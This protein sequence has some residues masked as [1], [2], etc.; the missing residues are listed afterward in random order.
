MTDTVKKYPNILLDEKQYVPSAIKASV[1]DRPTNP[2]EVRPSTPLIFQVATA[3]DSIPQWG[4]RPQHRDI[5]LRSFYKS[6]P[7]L[8]SAIYQMSTKIASVKWEVIGKDPKAAQPKNTINKTTRMLTLSGQGIG[9][10]RFFMKV[11]VDLYTQ[12]NGAFIELIREK[13]DSSSPVVML[14]NLDSGRCERT[15]DPE[16]PVVYLDRKNRWHK[17]AWYQVATVEEMPA[18]EE[19]MYGIQMCAVTRCLRAAQILRDIEIYKHEKVSGNFTRAVH[20]V[21][22]VTSSTLESAQANMLQQTLNRG[23]VRYNNTTILPTIDPEAKLDHVQIEMASL[24]DSFDEDSTMRQYITILAMA[25]GVDFQE[26][27]PLPGGGLGSSDQSD[28]LDKKTRGKG[29]SSILSLIEHII[30]NTGIIPSNVLFRFIEADNRAEGEIA[31]AR[32]TRGKDRSLRLSAKELTPRTAILLSV[33]DGD[34]PE[35]MAEAQLALL[36]EEAD[37][38]VTENQDPVTPSQVEGAEESREERKSLSIKLGSNLNHVAMNMADKWLLNGSISGRE[39]AKLTKMLVETPDVILDGKYV[40][41]NEVAINKFFNALQQVAALSTGDMTK[42]ITN[43][44]IKNE[45]NYIKDTYGTLS[46]DN[47]DETG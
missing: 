14:G 24:P 19:T 21:S 22:G 2:R 30:N 40:D 29:P 7:T 23:L 35:W 17:L 31:A 11:L 9:W 38:L 26:F 25:F 27:A 16:F 37:R 13:S 42:T 8:N 34:L 43:E 15:G 4:L 41:R 1:V 5:E 20:I 47:E 44:D 3:A 45:A 33:E 6:E 46:E 10:Q 39:Y 18:P 36:G 12:D 32:F 28:V